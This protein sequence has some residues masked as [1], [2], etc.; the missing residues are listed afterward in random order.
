MDGLNI[1]NNKAELIALIDKILKSFIMGS[2]FAV[3]M[4][5]VSQRTYQ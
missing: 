2:N 5:T 3:L 4:N 1:F